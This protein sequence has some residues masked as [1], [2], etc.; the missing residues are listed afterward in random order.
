MSEIEL[1]ELLVREG[2]L[3]PYDLEDIRDGKASLI[4]R[5]RYTA[6]VEEL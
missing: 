2:W 6:D 4:I 3:M 1:V 5:T